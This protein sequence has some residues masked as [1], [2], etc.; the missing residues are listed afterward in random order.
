MKP[1]LK[2]KWVIDHCG[3]SGQIRTQEKPPDSGLA[4]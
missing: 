1:Y 2:I 4:N 3:G